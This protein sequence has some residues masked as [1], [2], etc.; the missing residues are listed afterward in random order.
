MQASGPQPVYA[1]ATQQPSAGGL[2]ERG[3]SSKPPI[4]PCAV[5]IS[6]Q[7]SFKVFGFICDEVLKIYF[8]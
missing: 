8:I 1:A 4:K 2:E 6:P 3:V 5:L 7:I